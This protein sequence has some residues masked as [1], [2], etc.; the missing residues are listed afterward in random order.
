M[1]INI[2]GYEYSCM[3]RCID[4]HSHDHI[5]IHMNVDAKVVE[6]NADLVSRNS[7][8]LEG[9]SEYNRKY[10]EVSRAGN[11][12]VLADQTFQQNA[13]P[14]SFN[15]VEHQ[16]GSQGFLVSKRKCFV[17]Q[18]AEMS[19]EVIRRIE[20]REA[21]IER[22][23]AASLKVYKSYIEDVSSGIGHRE[24][25]TEEG[26]HNI[27]STTGGKTGGGYDF[28]NN[29]D[30]CM[31]DVRLKSIECVEAL[32]AW[33]RVCRKEER[34]KQEYIDNGGGLQPLFDH[35]VDNKRYC[36]IIAAKGIYK[37]MYIRIELI[38]D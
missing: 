4:K 8:L 30:T 10:M 27:G 17:L 25:V 19:A 1:Y 15:Q 32:G 35:A 22:L 7:V 9:T 5:C 24:T 34:K 11:R 6:A 3:Y 13:S 28:M 16:K 38:N 23:Q 21:A 29:L 2:H 37:Y 31:K 20:A 18:E 12:M 36:V 14:P 33:A 26:F